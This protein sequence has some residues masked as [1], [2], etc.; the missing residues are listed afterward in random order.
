MPCIDRCAHCLFSSGW[1][2]ACFG[3]HSISECKVASFPAWNTTRPCVSE[4]FY[5]AVGTLQRELAFW[6]CPCRRLGPPAD[7]Y[8]C[9]VWMRNC[10]C[11]FRS[12]FLY[13][14]SLF[15]GLDLNNFSGLIHGFWCIFKSIPIL[16]QFIYVEFILSLPSCP[17]PSFSLPVM[18]V[19][20]HPWMLGVELWPTDR[21]FSSPH[22]K[23][24]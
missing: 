3:Q 2:L 1:Y 11:C 10:F 16:K 8:W 12:C 22:I 20:H 4:P 9:A 18:C 24:S 13:Y 7:P 21:D 23:F 6:D 14:H 5:S 19:C 15:S 17:P